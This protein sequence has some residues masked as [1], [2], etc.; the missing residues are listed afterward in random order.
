M[1]GAPVGDT[2]VATAKQDLIV[3]GVIGVGLSK[4]MSSVSRRKL[5]GIFLGW[6][7]MPL[8]AGVFAAV[9]YRLLP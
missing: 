1:L 6:V 8:C 7:A 5:Y 3:G 2:T 9:L 4:G